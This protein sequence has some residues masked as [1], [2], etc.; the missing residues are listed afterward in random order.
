MTSLLVG[1]NISS[2]KGD[3]DILSNMSTKIMLSL[4]SKNRNK[5]ELSY[6]DTSKADL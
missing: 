4:A 1:C 2:L 6:F 5:E 3:I